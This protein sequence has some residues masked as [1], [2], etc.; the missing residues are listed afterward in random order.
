MSTVNIE[1][2]FE[3]KIIWEKYKFKILENF[4]L[5]DNKEFWEKVIPNSSDEN[6]K[7]VLYRKLKL[8]LR[9]DI[10]KKLKERFNKELNLIGN[11]WSYY[12]FNSLPSTNYSVKKNKQIYKG[13]ICLDLGCIEGSSSLYH[14]SNQII[15]SGGLIIQS[16]QCD[17]KKIWGD[18]HDKILF[19]NLPDLI[20]LLEKLLNDKKYCSIIL[21][22]IYNVF[23]N[24]DKSIEKS[25]D[26]VFDMAD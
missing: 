2:T 17:G 7:L 19:K 25:L 22:K 8:L 6:K 16:L 26:K 1:T 24:S 15:E 4:S 5:I 13:N 14:R 21:D 9:F 20:S 23:V 11:D 12:P 3:E 18:L 10:I